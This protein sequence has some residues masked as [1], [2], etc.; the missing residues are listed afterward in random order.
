M[1]SSSST[2]R[3]LVRTRALLTRLIEMPDLAATI[4][5]LPAERFAALVRELGVE[6][7]GELVALATTEQLVQAFDEDPFSQRPSW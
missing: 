1:T 3:P 4:Q 5:A 7:A 2:P 6:D